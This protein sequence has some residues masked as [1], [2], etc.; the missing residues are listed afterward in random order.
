[1][2]FKMRLKTAS[3]EAPGQE[4][5]AE[6]LLGILP[7]AGLLKMIVYDYVTMCSLE[8]TGCVD[9]NIYIYLYIYIHIIKSVYIY[10]IV[11]H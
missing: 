4:R 8:V 2:A 6:S 5:W 10:I 7:G 3:L 11:Y 9:N 1:M